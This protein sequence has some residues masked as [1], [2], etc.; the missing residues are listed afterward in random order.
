MKIQQFGSEKATRRP[1]NLFS[2]NIQDFFN[3]WL[4]SIC[5]AEFHQSCKNAWRKKKWIAFQHTSAAFR[6]SACAAPPIP[7][8]NLSISRTSSF[9]KQ[10]RTLGKCLGTEKE[11]RAKSSSISATRPKRRRK[12]ICSQGK[13]CLENKGKTNTDSKQLIWKQTGRL[14]RTGFEM[15]R[16]GA[17]RTIGGGHDGLF[18]L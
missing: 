13:K 6:F 5:S 10:N 4:K 3:S 16:T 12:K 17:Q 7:G 1:K 11:D 14:N 15:E 18:P 2:L 8:F 9:C